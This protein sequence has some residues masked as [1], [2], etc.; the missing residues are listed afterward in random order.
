MTAKTVRQSARDPSD[1][2][3]LFAAVILSGEVMALVYAATMAFLLTVFMDSDNFAAQAMGLEWWLRGA[4]KFGGVAIV[5][6]VLATAIFA[7]NRRLFP[8]IGLETPRLA[9]Q[10]AIAA[11]ALIVVPGAIGTASFVIAKPFI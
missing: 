4:A 1:E 10:T 6:A 11:A 8:W 7:V 9:L 5:A 2:K 3:R